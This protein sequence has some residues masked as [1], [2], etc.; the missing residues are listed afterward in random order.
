MTDQSLQKQSEE[1]IR[2]VEEI[3]TMV[4]RMADG[5]YPATANLRLLEAIEELGRFRVNWLME[6]ITK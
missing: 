1:I 2:H 6:E 4:R 5:G 3:K